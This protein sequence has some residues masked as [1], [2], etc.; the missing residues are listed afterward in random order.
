MQSAPAL[1]AAPYKLRRLSALM[2]E[3]VHPAACADREAG[4]S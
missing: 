2:P 3:V 1:Y 4:A